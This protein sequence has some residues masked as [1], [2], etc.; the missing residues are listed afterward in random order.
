M[1]HCARR[2]RIRPAGSAKKEGQK[3]VGD[4]YSSGIYSDSACGKSSDLAAQQ[5]VGLLSHQW[6][7]RDHPNYL[8]PGLDRPLVA[9]VAYSRNLSDDELLTTVRTKKSDVDERGGRLSRCDS[10]EN[11]SAMAGRSCGASFPPI[12][13]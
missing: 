5:E 11:F 9:E 2:S 7:K 12:S 10:A 3:H 1:A 8:I 6:H 13:N 4:D